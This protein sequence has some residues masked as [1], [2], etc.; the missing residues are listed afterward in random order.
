MPERPAARHFA[1][2]DFE[3]LCTG[4]HR[5]G[6]H[7]VILA[8]RLGAAV[9]LHRQQLHVFRQPQV[10]LPALAG[11]QPEGEGAVGG[12]LAGF[13]LQLAAVDRQGVAR[14]ADGTA[15]VQ[16][17][18][19]TRPGMPGGQPAVGGILVVNGRDALDPDMPDGSD[20]G[21]PGLQPV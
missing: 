8:Y 18:L 21:L 11:A 20:V 7:P 16:G 6:E 1:P 15:D 9:D 19:L 2:L 17:Y 14:Y 3:G 12:T 10:V 13:Y 5:Q 4:Y